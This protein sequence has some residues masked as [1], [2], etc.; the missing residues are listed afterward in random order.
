MK[1][2]DLGSGCCVETLRG[3]TDEVLSVCYN[4]SGSRMVSA[5]ADGTAFVHDVG[6]AKVLAH[7]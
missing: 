4:S 5:S 1:L 6:T 2:W 7:L 3:H